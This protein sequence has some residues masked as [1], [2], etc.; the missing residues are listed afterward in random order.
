MSFSA[1]SYFDISLSTRNT[2]RFGGCGLIK[3]FSSRCDY[4]LQVS[5]F[6][7][8]AKSRVAG[9]NGPPLTSQEA[10][11]NPN[12]YNIATDVGYLVCGHLSNHSSWFV[13]P[14]AGQVPRNR[15]N[16]TIC[17]KLWLRTT[18][19]HVRACKQIHSTT[20]ETGSQTS[21]L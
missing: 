14:A 4:S 20:N 2:E 12:L 16:R 19:I 11:K 21:S 10:K 18:T 7:T 13:Q 9:N 1:K 17:S 8:V 5:A 15:I 3:Y 6:S